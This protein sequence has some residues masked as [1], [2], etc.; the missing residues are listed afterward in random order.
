MSQQA[1]QIIINFTSNFPHLFGNMQK[2]LPLINHLLS[3]ET[4]NKFYIETTLDGLVYIYQDFNTFFL[5]NKPYPPEKIIKFTENHELELD[6]KVLPSNII[7]R[8]NFPPNGVHFQYK[9]FGENKE[10]ISD[11]IFAHFKSF[12]YDDVSIVNNPNYDLTLKLHK[13]ENIALY[14]QMVSSM[15]SGILTEAGPEI[16]GGGISKKIKN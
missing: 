6:P 16:T 14:N 15:Y 10:K 8:D 11:M 3:E 12:L 13:F 9:I 1:N 4:Q 7:N 2:Y 5:M